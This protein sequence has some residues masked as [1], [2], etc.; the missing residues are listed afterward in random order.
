MEA[1]NAVAEGAGPFQEL[2]SSDFVADIE[3]KVSSFAENIP[4]L[5]N[6][7]DEVTALHPAIQGSSV[8]NVWT[9]KRTNSC[10]VVALA[11]KAAYH[12]EMTRR[13]NDK[14][15]RTLY[16]EMK[17]MIYVLIQSVI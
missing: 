4:W 14:R 3:A 13:E 10:P 2:L 8:F 12:I 7:L 15:I 6:V 17:E 9:R 16:V 11:F 1:A 5:M